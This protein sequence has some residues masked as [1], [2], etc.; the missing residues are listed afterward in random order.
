MKIKIC[1]ITNIEDALYCELKGVDA[2]GFVFYEKSE[3]FINYDNARDIIE[4]LDP[5][6]LKVGV[7]VN[8]PEDEIN[9]ISKYVKLNLVQLHGDEEIKNYTNVNLPILRGIRIKDQNDII[10]IYKNNNMNLLLDTYQNNMYG[11]TGKMF[12]YNLV[13]KDIW[14]KSIIA[15]GINSDTIDK[16]LNM[17]ELPAGIDVSTGVESSKGKKDN[18]KIDRLIKKINE[19]R[20]KC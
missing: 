9:E 4:K 1:G 15:G 20:N 10:K 3:R 11:G 7:F 2:L 12:D 19:R 17:D 16:I 8:K 18:D 14:K 5:F 6:V 13:P